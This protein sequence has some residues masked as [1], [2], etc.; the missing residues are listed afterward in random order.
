MKEQFILSRAV[1]RA[2]VALEPT[3]R[4]NG[5][6]YAMH[7]GLQDVEASDNPMYAGITT[8]IDKANK[9]IPRASAEDIRAIVDRLNEKLGTGYRHTTEKTR[10][11][12]AARYAEGNNREDFIT[13]ID[14]MTEEWT[15]TRFERYLRP[16]TLFGA[17]FEGYLNHAKL[18]AQR[19]EKEVEK[20]SFDT[21][22]FAEAAMMRV[23]GG[24]I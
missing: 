11:L 23:Y 10:K 3:D 21:D 24:T 18:K 8:A 9:E 22:S 2:I 16:E 17:K 4:Y 6:I 19:T 15:G 12:I 7:Y 1:A 14:T 20:S 13:V 5:M